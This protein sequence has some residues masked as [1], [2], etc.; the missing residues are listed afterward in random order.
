MDSDWCR[1]V[2]LAT[3]GCG[4]GDAINMEDILYVKVEQN[5]P[6]RKRDLKLKDDDS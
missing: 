5:V 6:V 2:S 1:P 4:N 3:S